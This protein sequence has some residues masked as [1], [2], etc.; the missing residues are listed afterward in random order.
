MG[1][2][3][4]FAS[5]GGICEGYLALPE[6]AEPD[7]APGVVVIQEWWGMVPHIRHMADRFAAEGFVALVPDFYR[8]VRTTEPDEAAKLMMGL[9][10][11]KAALDIAGA[12]E[13]LHALPL[14]TSGH[15][16]AVGFCM[17]GG[18]ALLAPTVSERI[19]ATSGFYP[20][21]P[22]PD[23]R[24]EWSRYRGRSAQIH[25]SEDD[26]TSAAEGIQQMVDAI[27]TAGGQVETFD[28]PGSHHAFA[29][30]DR[31]EVYNAAHADAALTRTW[32]FLRRSLA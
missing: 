30:D 25:C 24:P 19:T 8:G 32:E 31:P 9:D 23:Y 13:Y 4:E 1:Q 6:G 10:V 21:T 18:L 22:W 14:T 26:G 29:N 5:N 27:A 2:I 12:A 16:G 3:V 7:T 20:A 11:G 28:Y 17:G 15:V